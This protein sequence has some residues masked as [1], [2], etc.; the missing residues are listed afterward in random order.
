MHSQLIIRLSTY[1]APT[2]NKHSFGCALWV[3]PSGTPLL[4]GGASWF[5]GR[6][7]TL[8]QWETLIPQKMR[9]S[10]PISQKPHQV[11][12]QASYKSNYSY[13]FKCTIVKPWLSCFEFILNPNMNPSC[14]CNHPIIKTSSIVE[15]LN[16][17]NQSTIT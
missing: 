1:P 7:P 10:Y 5:F 11:T 9:S 15:I 12:F 6:T 4:L 16:Q 13:N 17:L 3:S 8:H 14:S 2:H